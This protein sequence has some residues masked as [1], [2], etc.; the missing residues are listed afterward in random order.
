MSGPHLR[1]RP[2]E[3]I[4]IR[5]GSLEISKTGTK[6][7]D[8]N[9]PYH[10]AVTLSWPLFF[11]ALLVIDLIINTVFALLYMAQKGSVANVRPDSFVDLFFFSIETL[12]TVGYGV[13][14]PATLYGHILASIEILCGLTFTAIMTGLIFVRFSKPKSKIVFADKAVVTTYNGVPTLMIRIGNGRVSLL[15]DATARITAVV[16]ADSPEGHVFRHA[17]ELKL[18][19]DRLTLFVLTWTLIHP[20]DEHSPLHGLSRDWLTD[21][22]LWLVVLV[23]AVDHALGAQVHQIKDYTPE[24]IRF[25]ER[26]QDAVTIDAQGR[27]NVDMTRLSAVEPDDPSHVGGDS[28]VFVAETEQ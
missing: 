16:R 8:L 27:T 26:Y 9:D 19:R 5:V 13:A 11:L 1:R 15:A 14:A 17:H 6:R 2:H 28:V 3:P 7:Y 20:L 10:L 18:E 12:A 21:H 25:G 24:T 22:E 4:P 23:E